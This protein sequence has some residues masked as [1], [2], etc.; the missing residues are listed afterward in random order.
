MDD[1]DYKGSHAGHIIRA[2]IMPTSVQL[3]DSKFGSMKT[4]LYEKNRD[5]N[6][7]P[8]EKK[9]VQA[10]M[11]A[12][13]ASFTVD[14][15][16]TKWH[17][18][19]VEVVGDEMILTIDG[20]PVGYLKSEGVDHPTKNAVGFTIGGQSIQLDNVKLWEATAST[21]WAGQRAEVVGAIQKAP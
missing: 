3:D 1:T 2:T 16:L 11:K 7:T 20:K 6:T 8:E 18:A 19:R 10:A 13:A 21:N 14:F 12:K 4:E 17:H 9:Q 15:D 5:P